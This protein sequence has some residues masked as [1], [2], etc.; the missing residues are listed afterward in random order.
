MQALD[1]DGTV[2]DISTDRSLA[3]EE[4]Q[5]TSR[6]EN[7]PTR[8]A[9]RDDLFERQASASPRRS[10]ATPVVASLATASGAQRPAGSGL[11]ISK[12]A[13]SSAPS[14]QASKAST[15][16]D[17]LERRL[18]LKLETKLEEQRASLEEAALEAVNSMLAHLSLPTLQQALDELGLPANGEKTVLTA[19]LTDRLTSGIVSGRRETVR[20]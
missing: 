19:R 18:E 2:A 6:G 16:A 3:K 17:T 12:D 1:F 11:E 10:A 9:R 7:P 13:G 14:K 20:E 8:V 15:D 5:A 4:A